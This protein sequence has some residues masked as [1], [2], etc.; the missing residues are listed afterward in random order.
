M[1]K[2]AATTACYKAAKTPSMHLTSLQ[3]HLVVQR[4]LL[5][6]SSISSR[7]A[8]PFSGHSFTAHWAETSR[9]ASTHRCV[10]KANEMSRWASLSMW[11]TF[12]L[13]VQLIQ[14][15]SSSYG[16]LQRQRAVSGKL[17]RFSAFQRLGQDTKKYTRSSTLSQST[18]WLNSL[19]SSCFI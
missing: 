9:D 17:P 13:L 3:L 1:P 10:T 15:Q 19:N 18:N 11:L 7:V 6:V 5:H 4:L 14:S 12:L 16:I 2:T 8:K